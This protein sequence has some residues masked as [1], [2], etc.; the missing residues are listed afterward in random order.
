MGR[1][2]NYYHDL[3]WGFGPEDEFEARLERDNIEWARG[4]DEFMLLKAKR[5]IDNT[6]DMLE[7]E[8]VYNDNLHLD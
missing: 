2:K 4:L 3:L 8:T 6:I 7:D 1:I 5:D